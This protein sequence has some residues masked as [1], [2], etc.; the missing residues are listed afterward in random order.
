MEGFWADALVY[1]GID[2]TVPVARLFFPGLQEV[3][4]YLLL[5]SFVLLLGDALALLTGWSWLYAG[6]FSL[7]DFPLEVSDDTCG[8]AIP[9]S[10]SS[11]LSL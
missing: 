1:K 9:S 4:T 8:V 6:V 3:Q 11:S 10:L 2:G 7:G 5:G